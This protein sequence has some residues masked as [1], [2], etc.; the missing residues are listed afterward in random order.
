[1]QGKGRN[2]E[3]G[4]YLICRYST[5]TS[6]RKIANSLSSELPIANVS[7]TSMEKDDRRQTPNHHV[8][9]TAPSDR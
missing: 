9:A 2:R 7:K 8:P 5:C 3:T 4:R 6:S 1:M